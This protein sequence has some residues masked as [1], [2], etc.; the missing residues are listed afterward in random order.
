[1]AKSITYLPIR[2]QWLATTQEPAL[3]PEIPVVDTHHH[4]YERPEVRYLLDEFLEDMADGHDI[5]ATV[6]VQAR[7][8]LRADAPSHLQCLG[9][10]EFANG[11]A[12]MSASGVYGRSRVCA[13]IVGH[14]DLTLG[15]PVREVLERHIALAGGAP[16]EGGRFRGIRQPLAWDTDSR[17]TN[18]AYPAN[19]DTMDSA[20]FRAGFAQLAPLGL[21]FD[22][23]LFFHQLTR[24]AQ[25]ARDF[26]DTPIVVNHCGGIVRIGGHEGG[27]DDVFHIWKVGITELASC[28]NVMIKLSGLG[29]RLGGFGVETAERAPDS[30]TLAQ[31]WRPW[32]ETCIDAFGPE[33]CMYGSNFPVDK[34]TYQYGV[35]INA[36]KR[37]TADL[38]R[39]E[40]EDIFWRTASR[41]YRLNHSHG[42]V[43][44]DP[45]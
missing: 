34:G 23:W 39:S 5:R 20:A 19:A 12:A 3:E 22:A 40:K 18:P 2:P 33:R 37:L 16:A 26:P 36:L 44:C 17:L 14:A 9:E 35:G 8:M 21:S 45:S 25:L 43:D 11:I 32:V 41:F 24:L 6:Y 38:S 13:G 31:A 29:M 30:R 15:A 10:T 42:G 28:P 7:A 27:G 4:L 1:M